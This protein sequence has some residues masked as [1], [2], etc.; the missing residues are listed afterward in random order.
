MASDEG[1]AAD[2]GPAGDAGP[3]TEDIVE[4][5]P[6]DLVGTAAE[7]EVRAGIITSADALLTGLKADGR[8]GDIKMM[9]ARASF[10][11]EAPGRAAGGYRYYGGN[12]VDA[13]PTGHTGGDTFGEVWHTY[14]LHAFQPLSMELLSD[15]RDGEAVVRFEGDVQI[16][17]WAWS[18]LGAIAGGS[19][20]EL[21]V[22]MEYRMKPDEPFVTRHIVLT[23]NDPDDAVNM[24]LPLTFS[25]QGDG[26]TT[27]QPGLGLDF[28][29]GTVKTLYF[30][31][32]DIGHAI[33]PGE[34]DIEVIIDYSNVLASTGPPIDILP[35]KSVTLT[36][37]HVVTRGGAAGV[38]AE[39]A[40]ITEDV[41]RVEAKLEGTVAL[42]AS[43]MAD[44]AWLA[45]F[46]EGQ[47]YTLAPI[48]TDGTLA[49]ELAKGDYEL[50]AFLPRHAPSAKLAVSLSAGDNALPA[51]L[52][53]AEAGTAKVTLVDPEGKPVEGRVTLLAN[54]DTANPSAP[55]NVR[56]GLGGQW[57]WS[58]NYGK[59]S[60]VGYAIGGE[61]TVLVPAG[62]YTV[63]ASRGFAYEIDEAELTVEAGKEA[64][65]T[66]TL[67]R[68]VDT[69]GWVSGDFHIHATRSPDSDTPYD[70]R[71]RQAVTENLDIPILTEHVQIGGLD[72][73]A[74][75]LGLDDRMI[76]THAQEV[77]TF[78]YGHF[79]AFP[80]VE[81]ADE[82]NY[83]AVFP[84]DKRPAELF[85]AIRDQSP[86]DEII[87]VNHP[88]GASLGSYFSWA[89]LNKADLSVNK[90]DEWSTN[91]DAIEVFNGNCGSGDP[92]E[93]WIAMTNAGWGKTLASG[94]DSHSEDDPIGVPRNWI[95][96][97][98]QTAAAEPDTLVKQVRE[99]RL[100]VSCG[101]FVT[102][103][104]ANEDAGLGD[105]T[106]VDASGEVE[107]R[108]VVQAPS[109]VNLKEARLIRN[110]EIIDVVPIEEAAGGVRLDVMLSDTPAA[111]SWY[112]V[113]VVGQG[114][115]LPVH[116]NGPP[117]AYTNPIFVDADGNGS[118]TAPG[119]P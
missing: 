89:G 82:P 46:F 40:R 37:T 29:G 47:P 15:G 49:I 110:G 6:V 119:L 71:A 64:T 116:K 88:R 16:F 85:Q 7:G 19:P 69:T 115:L 117:R 94:S 61:T 80:M 105:T 35:G 118:Y 24:P 38:E 31:E 20:I 33:I 34:G 26:L 27:W 106:I 13:L 8:L 10:I 56:L 101:P 54:G 50:Q 42:P 53:I 93:D 57:G 14:N 45:V 68:V 58:G 92:L 4:P 90:E 43:A 95:H 83:G 109:W 96:L 78:E 100:F 114:N 111:D 79:N 97:D 72:P 28:D 63:V 87:Q 51:G 112:V 102:F 76:G 86:G 91:F 62:D 12:I 1:T 66:L 59:V 108:L 5:E 25:N 99:G 36:Y 3:E 18:F 104:T 75:E 39:V 52:S 30:I 65:A 17:W 74:V 9:N 70:V 73:I 113:D 23:N 60:A 81:N 77:T 32:R 21:D 44:T 11:I 41:A 55:G 2:E 107:W 84:Y 48:A 67:V 103:T 98:Y 22:A